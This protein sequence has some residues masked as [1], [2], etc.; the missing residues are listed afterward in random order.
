MNLLHKTK[1]QT[2]EQRIFNAIKNSKNMHGVSNW[3]LSRIAL[4]YTMRIS[5]LRKDGYNIMATRD[6]L[7]NG[8]ATNTFRYH[9]IEEEN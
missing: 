8:R 2:Q 6:Y 5:E 9:L 1:P 4:N 3:E 7:P